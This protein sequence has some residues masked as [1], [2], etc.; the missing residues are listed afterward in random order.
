MTHPITTHRLDHRFGRLE[1]LHEVTLAVPAGSVFALLGPNGAGKSTLIRILLN[2]IRPSGGRAT[3]LGTPSPRIGPA[4]L[5]EIGYV[6]ETQPVPTWMTVER[7]LA[8]LRPLYPRWDEG[9]CDRLLHELEVPR[10]RKLRHLSRG[11]RVK[12]LLVA[13]LAYR[14]R[15]L[16]LDEPFGGLDPL[17]RDGLIDGVLELTEGEEWT[18][19]VASHDLAEVER[20]AD[21]IGVID[22][23]R[24]IVSEELA[25][26]QR[27][28]RHLEVRFDSEPTTSFPR[29]SS[30][31]S[32]EAAGRILR[33]VDAGWA[34][35]RSAAALRKL[36]PSASDVS[37]ETMSLGEIYRALAGRGGPGGVVGRDEAA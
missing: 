18:V 30:W 13:A 9:L 4:E 27:R 8:Y 17:T 25:A 15:L 14:P 33:I 24:L 7:L 2:L 1:V 6:S 22:R 12:A 32:V 20:L 35:E 11:E 10:N 19:L 21:W 5:A 3:V 28:F 36:L 23:G 31:L 29:P 26:L 16:I 37:V 34:G